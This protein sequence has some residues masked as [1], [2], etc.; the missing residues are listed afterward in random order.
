[1]EDLLKLNFKS[2]T[3]KFIQYLYLYELDLSR[4]FENQY[5][6]NIRRGYEETLAQVF[7]SYHTFKSHINLKVKK[8]KEESSISKVLR[9]MN[10]EN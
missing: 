2:D 10:N 5:C 9:I 6:N 8:L 7:M 4:I 1:M 3:E